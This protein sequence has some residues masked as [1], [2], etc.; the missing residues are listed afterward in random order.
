MK[1]LRFYLINLL[2][3]VFGTSFLKKV[4][5]ILSTFDSRVKQGSA[6]VRFIEKNMHIFDELKVQSES[7]ARM[8]LRNALEEC[9][10]ILNENSKS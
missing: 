3:F 7:M 9:A 6:D 5:E 8:D 2:L 10:N 1:K 4:R